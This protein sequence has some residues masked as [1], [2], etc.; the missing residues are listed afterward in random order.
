MVKK[1]TKKDLDDINLEISY[2]WDKIKFNP[3]DKESRKKLQE[4]RK[5]RK[6]IQLDLDL[7]GIKYDRVKVK[8]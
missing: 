4:L 2:I 7:Q 5:K 1:M 6:E 8:N 3:D